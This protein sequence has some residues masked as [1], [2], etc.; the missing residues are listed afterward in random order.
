MDWNI[1]FPAVIGLIGVVVGFL[2]NLWRDKVF[3]DKELEQKEIEYQRDYTEK[4]LIMP[5]FS[6]IDELMA[7]MDHFYGSGIKGAEVDTMVAYDHLM[8]KVGSMKARIIALN[9]KVLQHTYNEF[10]T[11]MIDFMRNTASGDYDGK[12][13]VANLQNDAHQKAGIIFDRLKPKLTKMHN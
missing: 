11:D 6:S 1:I 8:D 3:K 12:G 2:L 10:I 5:L 13:E 7:L 4:Y 9:D